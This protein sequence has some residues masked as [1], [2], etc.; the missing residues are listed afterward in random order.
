MDKIHYDNWKVNRWSGRFIA[1]QPNKTLVKQPC[2]DINCNNLSRRMTKTNKMTCAPSE[3]SDQHGHP[4]RPAKT[5][6]SLGIHPYWSKSSLHARGNINIGSL[7]THKRTGNTL[8][9]LGGCQGWS[10]SSLGAEVN[11]LVLSFSGSIRSYLSNHF[12]QHCIKSFSLLSHSVYRIFHFLWF[13]QQLKHF[14]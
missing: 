3:V 7:A 4:P 1:A 5:L 9:R 12:T 8:I 6:I 2:M 13:I 14:M 10:E 11:L